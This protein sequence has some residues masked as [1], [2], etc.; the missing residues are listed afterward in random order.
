MCSLVKLSW[1]PPYRTSIANIHRTAWMS[2]SGL[3]PSIRLLIVLN[4]S[5]ILCL[6]HLLLTSWA[7]F[8][9]PHSQQPSFT[10]VRPSLRR[11]LPAPRHVSARTLTRHPARPFHPK[12]A[13]IPF[14]FVCSF[15]VIPPYSDAI[16]RHHTHPAW[17][18][19][20]HLPP[21]PITH[22]FSLT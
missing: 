21:Y 12:N 2:A 17:L 10:A 1:L 16:F 8:P 4:N 22:F 9:H 15:A 19:L 3:A 11:G 20:R 7:S 13:K 14:S 5:L 18:L 6:R